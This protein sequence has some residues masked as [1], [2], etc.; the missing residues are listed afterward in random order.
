MEQ[1]LT[2]KQKAIYEFIQ[3]YVEEN[4]MPPSLRDIGSH[5]DLS[6]GTVQDQVEAIRR[7][8]F[9]N[10]DHTKARGLRLPVPLQQIPI[11]G[12]VH[13]GP[14]H[15][16]IENVEGHL[17]V[18]NTLS[19]SHHFGLRIRGNSM[20][21]AGI[22]EGDIV[23]VRPQPTAHDGD[24]VVAR[25]EDEATVKRLRM[26][27]NRVLLE[28]ENPDYSPIEMPFTVIGV[29]VEVRRHYRS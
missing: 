17:P 21:G 20:V 25:V 8:G 14:L 13:A 16:A 15:A 1:T 26:R 2:P 10:K 19:A 3:S 7:K 27:K 22:M 4:Q 24:I 9:L 12:R 5:F 29:V 11:L 28:P 6:V 23:I 18:G